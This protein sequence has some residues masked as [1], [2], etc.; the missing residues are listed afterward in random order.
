[1]LLEVDGDELA[2]RCPRVGIVDGG[3]GGGGGGGA[4]IGGSFESSGTRLREAA[5]SEE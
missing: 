2:L 3:G 1:L 5:V 4:G